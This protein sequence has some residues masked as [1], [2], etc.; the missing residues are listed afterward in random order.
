MAHYKCDG[1][2]YEM[3]LHEELKATYSENKD[4]KLQIIRVPGG[5]LYRSWYSSHE[6]MTFV[7]Y[8]GDTI[9]AHHGES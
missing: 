6:T 8:S 4:Y 2:I 1:D 3:K 5:W 7:P 9:D